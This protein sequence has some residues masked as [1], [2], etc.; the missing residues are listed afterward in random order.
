M[1]TE[2]F[3]RTK[4]AQQLLRDADTIETA[5]GR[6]NA[7]WARFWERNAD[8]LGTVLIGHLAVEHYIDDWLTAANP[9]MKAVGDTRLSFAQKVE[10]L[11]GADPSVQ[12]LLP[13]LIRLNRIRNKL[14]HDLDAEIS[15]RDLEPLRNVVWPWHSAGGKPCNSGIALVKDFALLVCGML[16]SQ[17]HSI[18]RYGDGC[19]LVAYQR[20]LKD[21]M[22][23]RD[24][25]KE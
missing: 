9:G 23:T 24:D 21:A 5:L 12:W 22:G 14:A 17:A 1:D 11:D 2:D 7:Q 4:Y 20:W 19:G 8:H 6:F 16:S 18:R 3:L 13:G 10:L 15:E 25:E